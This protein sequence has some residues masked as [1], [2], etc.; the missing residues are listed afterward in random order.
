MCSVPN[1][2]IKEIT[3]SLE[4]ALDFFGVNLDDEE[5][6]NKDWFQ[7]SLKLYPELLTDPASKDDLRDLKNS[8]VKKYRGA[9]LDVTGKFT[10]VLPDLYAFCEW[11]FCG[12]ENPIGLLDDGEVFCKLYKNEDKLDCLRSPHLYIEHAIRKNV[13]NKKYRKQYLSE[14]FTTD[15]V[16]TSTHDLISRILQFDDH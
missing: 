12:I 7:K 10:F 14:W 5:E 9:K 8:L 13:C 15:A 2:K 6:R 4:N 3:D 11:L 16:Y 1:K